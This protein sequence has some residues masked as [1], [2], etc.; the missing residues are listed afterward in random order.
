MKMPKEAARIFL[1]VTG[2]R[3]ERL[4]EITCEE[5][6]KEGICPYVFE[7][8]SKL[9]AE[10]V[11]KEGMRI[12]MMKT[13]SSTIKKADMNQY[14]YVANPWV[15]VIEFERVVVDEKHIN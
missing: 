5:I 12:N 9:C 4:Q 13:W 2:V 7:G 11:K 14:S 15:W 10:T 8:E 6:A 3:V 1:R